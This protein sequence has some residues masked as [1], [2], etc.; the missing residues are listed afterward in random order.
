MA[1]ARREMELTSSTG[2]PASR[3]TNTSVFTY[4]HIICLRGIGEVL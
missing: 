2:K 3:Y 1:A 4:A